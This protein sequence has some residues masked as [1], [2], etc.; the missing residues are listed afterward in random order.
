M[1]EYIYLDMDLVNSCLAQLDEGILTKIITGQVSNNS[2][3]ED[4]GEESSSE[5]DVKLGI[6][7]IANTGVKFSNT[8]I[9]KFSTVYSQSNSELIETALAD[10]STDVLLNKLKE[11][12]K[13]HTDESEWN[14][15]NFIFS[16]HK[17]D[18]FNFEQLKQS[19]KKENIN[20]MLQPNNEINDLKK[21]LGILEKNTASRTKHAER[22]LLIKQ[23]IEENDYPKNFKNIYNFASYSSFLFPDTILFKIGKSLSMCTKEYIR[24]NTPLLTFLSQ[25]KRKANIFGIVLA[26]RDESLAPNGEEQLETNVIAS[27][28]PAIFND[29]MLES[30]NL[31][32][33]GDYFIRPIAIY[34]DHE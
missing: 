4:G 27:T 19:T 7:V 9:D 1:K 16:A 33:N 2:H 32:E 10:F 8:K 24:M 31:I 23:I 26:R 12:G 14:D 20:L 30:F 34:Y 6:P 15:G 22:I 25:T 5:K 11:N 18:V 29:I 21:E 13:L 3:Q 17:L 28:G